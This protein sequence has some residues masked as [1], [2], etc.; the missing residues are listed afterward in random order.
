MRCLVVNDD[1]VVKA[2]GLEAYFN[3]CDDLLFR[4][5]GLVPTH[6]KVPIPVTTTST[7]PSTPETTVTK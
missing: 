5:T 6:Y 1:E 7:V 4:N 2:Y 3:V